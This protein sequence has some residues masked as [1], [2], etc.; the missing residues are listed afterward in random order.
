[1]IIQSLGFA[2]YQVSK[3]FRRNYNQSYR[4]NISFKNTD[5][6]E[7]ASTKFNPSFYKTQN[8]NAL[9]PTV[10]Q[11]RNETVSSW[12]DFLKDRNDC[13]EDEKIEIMNSITGNLRDKNDALPPTPD[14]IAFKSANIFAK[15]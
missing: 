15:F 14:D 8:Y 11:Y 10:V 6:F 7:K 9:T 1:M 5:S 2:N 13:S 4:Y 3:I 12:A